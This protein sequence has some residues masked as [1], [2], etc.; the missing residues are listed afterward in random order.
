[1]DHA[2]CVR[3]EKG[4]RD[5]VL[6]E[7][8]GKFC[9]VGKMMQCVKI[10]MTLVCGV[11]LLAACGGGGGAGAGGNAVDPRLARLDAY[12]AQNLRVLG[13]AR[14]G[15]P[16]MA[17]A[18]PQD[19]P[20]GG[21]ASFVGGTTIRVELQSNPLVLYGDAAIGVDFD[22]GSVDGALTN[23]FGGVPQGAIADYAGEITVT[24]GVPAQ[25]MALAYTGALSTAGVSLAFDGMLSAIFLG[26]PVTAI[27]ASDLAAAVIHNGSTQ[28]A[29]I[30][31]IGEGIVTPPAQPPDPS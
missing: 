27:V 26:A 16:A 17:V 2:L 14:V 28:D 31:V 6:N 29:T 20:L 7:C 25:N 24:G 11:W 4:N 13:D 23:F 10:W 8:F 30:I 5:S 1:M 18:S 19:I 15:I 12:E 22:M 21:T 9:Y 3:H